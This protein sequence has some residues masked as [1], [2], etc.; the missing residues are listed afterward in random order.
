[1]S[2][3]KV[4]RYKKSKEN[5]K[6]ELKKKKRNDL[7]AKICTILI[8]VAIVSFIGWSIYKEVNPNKSS[9]DATKYSS[10]YTEEEFSSMWAAQQ[11]AT[12]TSGETTAEGETTKKEDTTTSNKE[13]DTTPG[14]TS[15]G[16]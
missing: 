10:L 16:E 9:T 7:I 12:T 13:Q 8:A 14:E 3:E 15:A 2:Q 11:G 6:I 1:M 4:D 5:R